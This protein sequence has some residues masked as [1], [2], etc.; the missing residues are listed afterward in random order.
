MSHMKR[1]AVFHI[2]FGTILGTALVFSLIYWGL[3]WILE[4]FGY[5]GDLLL[6]RNMRLYFGGLWAVVHFLRSGLR[7][8]KLGFFLRFIRACLLIA[9]LCLTGYY[10]YEYMLP[11]HSIE[12]FRQIFDQAKE[13]VQKQ[14][15]SL[16]GYTYTDQ[17]DGLPEVGIQ[18]AVSQEE[19]AKI[20]EENVYCLPDGLLQQTNVIRIL[21]DAAFTRAMAEHNIQAG[22]L[23]AGFSTY[24]Y[25]D[26]G[27]GLLESNHD[28]EVFLRLESLEPSTTAHE[29][30]HCFDFE[31]D[32]TQKNADSEYTETVRRIYESQPA[33]I[34]AYGATDIS[35][36]FAEAGSL[37]IM[38]PGL[39][40]QKSPELYGVL[41][42]L[43]GPTGE[44]V[45]SSQEGFDLQQWLRDLQLPD[46]QWPDLSSLHF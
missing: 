32:I 17:R 33:L 2:T 16:D 27:T 34:S 44:G 23:V 31:H 3:P 11:D 8:S 18:A 20:L 28:E 38:D 36:F 7:H 40:Q 25:T 35:E 42:A 4:Y 5:P 37:Y 41:E 29:L 45:P 24:S 9:A 43:Y 12:Q 6:D 46:I 21:D 39:L 30:T 1:H 10:V 15:V 26:N 22:G 19:A 14:Q 13:A